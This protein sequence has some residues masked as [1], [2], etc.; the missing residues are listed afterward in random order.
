M[1]GLGWGQARRE[2][3]WLLRTAIMMSAGALAAQVVALAPGRI[4]ELVALAR[5]FV[6]TSD[7]GALVQLGGGLA[8]FG[9]FAARSATVGSASTYLIAKRATQQQRKQR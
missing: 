1:A 6:G 3:D 2:R 7:V 8:Q 4:Q 9:A 5:I